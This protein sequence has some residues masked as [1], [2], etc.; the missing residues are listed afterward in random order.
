M[1]ISSNHGR[2]FMPATAAV[3]VSA[4]MSQSSRY[5]SVA[6]TE[7]KS[8]WDLTT[9]EFLKR[10][11]STE[12]TPETGSVAIAVA[13]MGT[14]LLRKALAD[15]LKNRGAKAAI[16][17]LEA[18]VQQLDACMAAFREG[19]D[20][21]GNMSSF[22]PPLF[23]LPH[24][25]AAE[26]QLREEVREGAAQRAISISIAHA[27]EVH[28]LF[29][30]GLDMLTLIHDETLT[31]AIAGLR[32]LNSASECLLV[33]AEGDLSKISNPEYRSRMSRHIREIDQ[34]AREA[35]TQLE[36]R[37]HSRQLTRSL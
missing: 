36:R 9:Q 21:D 37:I 18:A 15:S 11:G 24:V 8:L 1:I 30:S 22:Q 6:F 12:A 32:L 2:K 35:D 17:P 34:L 29:R 5:E 19:V 14:A 10:V 7:Q 23:R 3:K 16:L 27:R 25:D 28:S 13:S 4:N 20:E 33:M 26:T 31:C